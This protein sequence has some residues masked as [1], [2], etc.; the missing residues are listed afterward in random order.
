MSPSFLL[1]A[2]LLLPLLGG[3]FV[4]L[5][6]SRPNLREA[7]T[8]VTA[9]L[10]AFTVYALLQDVLA[11]G[12]PAVTL[13]EV[14]PGLPLVLEVEPLGMLFACV[15]GGLW[16]VNS[17]YSIGYMRGNDEKHQTR[18]YVCFTIAIASAMGIAFAGNMFTL[19]IFYEALTLST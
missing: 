18:F 7:V 6:G 19:F 16:I 9:G 4:A 14:V 12:R 1:A 17:L 3:V 15:A 5:T 11:G 10:L 13:I 2:T 8:L